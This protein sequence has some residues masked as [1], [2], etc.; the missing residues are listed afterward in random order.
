MFFAYEI[1]K[2][3]LYFY[4]RLY[5]IKVPYKDLFHATEGFSDACLIGTGGFSKVFKA[6][7]FNQTVAIKRMEKIEESDFN[8]YLNEIDYV[9]KF[10][11]VNLLLLLAISHDEQPCVIYEFME[12]GSLLNC[13]GCK[14]RF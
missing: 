2:T 1:F 10:K 4:L 8:L 14:V 7:F 11:H 5:K 9:L 3:I 12:N 13:I 6:N